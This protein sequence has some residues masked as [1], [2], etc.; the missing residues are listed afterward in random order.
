MTMRC[1]SRVVFILAASCFA[2]SASAVGLSVFPDEIKISSAAGEPVAGKLKIKNPSGEVSVFEVYPDDFG[3]I[4]KIIPAS[5]ILE[6]G[7]EKEIS[8]RAAAREKGILKTNISV[9]ATPVASSSFNT[10]NGVKI[11]L[12]ITIG[13]SKFGFASAVKSLPSYPAMALA[14]GLLFLAAAL[15]FF[16][17][18]HGVKIKKIKN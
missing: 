18:R 5:F 9:I 16:A 13:K 7:Q 15:V 3:E 11:P 4:V 12:E 14:A 10:G 1:L 6:S 8:V 17:K 2:S